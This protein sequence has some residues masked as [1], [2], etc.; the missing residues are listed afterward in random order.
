MSDI[1]NLFKATIKTVKTR[2]KLLNASLIDKS[3]LPK[4]SKKSEFTQNAKNVVSLHLRTKQILC[5]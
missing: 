1:T 3:I 4:S 5:V 2:E